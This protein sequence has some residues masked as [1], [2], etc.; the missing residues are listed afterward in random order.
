M[1]LALTDSLDQEYRRYSEVNRDCQID[2]MVEAKIRLTKSGPETYICT[3]TSEV[4]A[5]IS[6][7]S[8][9]D[10]KKTTIHVY[11]VHYNFRSEY[12]T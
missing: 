11:S 5:G 12:P 7:A 10:S 8:Y 1:H 9:N 2:L 6:V 3:F 4:E